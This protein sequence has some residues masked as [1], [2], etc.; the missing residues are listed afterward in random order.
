MHLTAVFV[1]P[2]AFQTRGPIGSSPSIETLI[3]PVRRYSQFLYID[4]GYAFFAPDPGPSH[5][6]QAA[7]D[8]GENSSV[9]DAPMTERMIPDLK[10]QWPRLS[11]HRHFMLAEF[12]NEIYHPQGP[13]S[14]L[15]EQ[16][17]EEASR[18]QQSRARY[19]AVRNSIIKHLEHENPGKRVRI[20]RLEHRLPSFV[21]MINHPIELDDPQLYRILAD[22]AFA[23]GE[24][25]EDVAPLPNPNL[26][27][28]ERNSIQLFE[29]D[30]SE[31]SLQ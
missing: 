10:D 26:L 9:A 31:E 22:P 17:L 1:P 29:D 6:I 19:V 28:K 13:P 4:R 16:N 8:D 25:T 14:S 18:W 30:R 7:M 27:P 20:R 3:A 23:S 5:L 11:Y 15:V 24:N 2:L 12:L 21:E